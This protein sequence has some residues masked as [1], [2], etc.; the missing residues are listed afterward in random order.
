MDIFDQE[1]LNFWKCLNKHEV[2]YIMVGGVAIN[3]NGYQ[4]ATADIDV[5][6]KD[7]LPNRKKL[8]IAFEEYSGEDFDIIERLQF[9]PGWTDF[10]LNNG[11]RLDLLVDMKGLEGFTFDE[12]LQVASIA[13]I[14]EVSIPFLHINHLIANKKAV[15]R[16]KDQAD[17]VYLER[18]KKLREDNPE[19]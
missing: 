1:L 17:I 5:W 14:D 8:R 10:H 4:R 11:F 12:C 16:P 13:E 6:I 19:L 18:I 15:N 3:L 9:V 2:Q 7:T